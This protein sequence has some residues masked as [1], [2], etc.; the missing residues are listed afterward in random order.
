MTVR[1][2]TMKHEDIW[3]ALDALAAENGLSASGLARRA[4]LDPTA[5]NPSKRRTAD[6]RTRWFSTETLAKV[7][8]A[9]GLRLGDFSIL[10]DGAR[11]IPSSQSQLRRSIPLIGLAQA[12][13]SG[14][15]DDGGYPAGAGWDEVNSLE[16]GDPS[17]YALEISGDSMEPVYRDGD[18][19]VVSP[20]APIRRGD[21]VVTRTIAG[22]VLAK[23][24]VRRSA[25]RIEL[26]S[27]NPEHSDRIFDLQEIAWVQRIIWASQ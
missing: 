2:V 8:H 25:R 10:I 26:R 24:L 21:R 20:N 5:F 17:A 11:A 27:L 13:S 7:L 16:I 23:Q 18:M 22:E 14:Y 1:W 4:G 19:I 9:T 6:G 12:G 3:R 15:F